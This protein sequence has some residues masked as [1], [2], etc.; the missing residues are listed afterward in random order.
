MAIDFNDTTQPAQFQVC[1]NDTKRFAVSIAAPVG[2]LL[3]P[4]MLSENDFLALKGKGSL[5]VF[6]VLPHFVGAVFMD[7]EF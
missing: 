4:N 6:C 5:I 2:E 7:D 3:Q 1:F